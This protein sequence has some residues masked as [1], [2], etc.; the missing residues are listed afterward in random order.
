MD[1]QKL[2]IIGLVALA[3]ISTAVA[4]AALAGVIGPSAT[5]ADSG[6][7]DHSAHSHDKQKTTPDGEPVNESEVPEDVKES[8]DGAKYLK[9]SLNEDERFANASVQIS[10]EGEVVVAYTSQADS[11]PALKQEMGEVAILY[12]DAVQSHNSTG[13][14]TVQANGVTLMVSS[15]AAEAHADGKID[16]E[17]FKETFHWETASQESDN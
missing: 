12:A 11:G 6:G 7:H 14:L 9:Q 10:Q 2:A 17:A 5:P 15:D 1:Y 8:I 16:E 4:G 13:G 3:V